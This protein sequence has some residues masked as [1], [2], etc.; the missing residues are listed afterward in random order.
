M[1]LSSQGKGLQLGVLSSGKG[2][3]FNP[4]VSGSIVYLLKN[5]IDLLL[6]VFIRV[7]SQACLEKSI[8]CNSKELIELHDCI[9]TPLPEAF[10]NRCFDIHPLFQ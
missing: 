4:D 2:F 10:Q 6:F 5:L 3:I 1:Y 7:K 8:L 9:H